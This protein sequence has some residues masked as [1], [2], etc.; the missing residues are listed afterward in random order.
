MGDMSMSPS[1]G[2]A[3]GAEHAAVLVAL[4]YLPVVL[5]TLA[6][7]VEVGA[8][9]G[10]AV[11]V[12]LREA[13]L[14]TSPAVLLAILGMAVSATVHLALV[15]THL[16]EDPALGVLFAFDGLA[17]LVAAAWSLT[18]PVPGGRFAGAVLLVAGVLAYAW[19]VVTGRET[20]DAVGIGTKLVELA[21]VLLLVLPRR[22]LGPGWWAHRPA[23]SSREVGGLTR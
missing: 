17:L 13:F 23:N 14:A 18:R 19:Y 15:P 10:L 21:S 3:M 11:A 12:R 6:T 5:T 2:L 20:A 9:S 22:L 16:T 7:A 1:P 8:R 4:L